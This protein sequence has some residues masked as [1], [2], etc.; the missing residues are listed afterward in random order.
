MAA[1]SAIPD[2]GAAEL[3][4]RPPDRPG[5]PTAVPCHHGRAVLVHLGCG[6]VEEAHEIGVGAEATVA[7]GDPELGRQP[8]RH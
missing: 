1:G 2:F 5:H 8:G 6:Q 3:G 4:A 7:D